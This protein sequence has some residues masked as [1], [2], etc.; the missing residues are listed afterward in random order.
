M[1]NAMMMPIN[2]K[3]DKDANGFYISMPDYIRHHVGV[4]ALIKENER[5]KKMK[6]LPL[7]HRVYFW[8]LV[9]FVMGIVSVI[10]Y[11]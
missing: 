1:T 6:L 3:H 5:L 4:V 10:R 11:T 9:G 7:W 8:W 2:A